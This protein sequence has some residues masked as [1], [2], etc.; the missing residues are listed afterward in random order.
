MENANNKWKVLPAFAAL[1][2]VWGSTYLAILVGLESM[3]PLVM[4]C[5]RF[6]IAGSL[7]FACCM[8]KK[9]PLPSLQAIGRNTLYGILMLFGGTVSVTW[10]EQYL[11]S[12]L[13]AI[14]V[15]SLPF[16]FVLLDRKQWA[17]YFSNI[18]I[19]SGLLLGFAG[20]ALLVSFQHP[21]HA[22]NV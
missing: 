11:P 9:E 3:S 14:I 12:S 4:S 6:F 21:V 5:M 18:M 1:Y 13:A 19:I 15:T 7:L 20:V 22:K 10:A 17:F 8:Y 2:I 16:W